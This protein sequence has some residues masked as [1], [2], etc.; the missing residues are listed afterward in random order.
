M[1]RRTDAF[2][3]ILAV[4]EQ[5]ARRSAVGWE[6]G[7]GT[8]EL[9]QQP[10]ADWLPVVDSFGS[11]SQRIGP[12]APVNSPKARCGNGERLARRIVGLALV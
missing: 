9:D 8:N 3:N 10:C 2:V 6:A 12:A 4:G 1:M 11:M 5:R 7:A